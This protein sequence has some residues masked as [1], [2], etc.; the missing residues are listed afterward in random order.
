MADFL[1]PDLGEGLTE[2]EIMTWLVD[3]GDEVTVDQPVVEVETAKASVEVPVPF[4]GVVTVLHAEP[5]DVLAVGT[6]L[7]TI[8]ETRRWETSFGGLRE[9][10]VEVAP[11]GF[12]EKSEEGAGRSESAGSSE[13]TGRGENAGSGN[14]LVGYGTS[15][16]G[17]PTPRRRRPLRR[18][19]APALVPETDA[20]TPGVDAATP[21]AGAVAP[22]PRVLPPGT[23]THALRV[24]SPL[25]RRLA[26]ESGLDLRQVTGS[27]P[28]GLILRA[29]VE[30]AARSQPE[31][32]P[33]P[34][35]PAPTLP[36]TTSSGTVS[37]ES[38]RTAA[39]PPPP[40]LPA[41]A[42][43]P[44]RGFERVPLTGIRRVAAEKLSRS[45]REIPEA[46]LWVDADATG[47]LEARAVLNSAPPGS[48]PGTPVSIV[49]LLARFG[50][51]GL[52]RYPELNATV[53]GGEIHRHR[54]VHLGFAA[55]TDRGLVVP[56]IKDADLLSTRRLA[57]A[58]SAMTGRARESALTPGDLTGGTFTV[59]NYGVFGTDGAAA[60]I[61]HPEAAILGIGRIIERPWAVAGQVVVR[62]V[63]QLTL[64]FD[65]RVCDGAV[66]GG[67]L[68]FVA[69]CVERPVAA[70]GDL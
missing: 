3:V 36:E 13:T 63:T 5:G 19:G 43:P 41:S 1:L 22:T 27:G 10:G 57:G 29:D 25:V 28:G 30:Q 37:S 55:Q 45:R 18:P 46:T 33:G 70:L 21:D 12:D 51:A 64:S 68:R 48:P 59:N 4:A 58:I 8:A 53:E 49:A 7:I 69:D 14:V 50:V 26:R 15:S 60:I 67:F 32:R 31:R 34:T 17:A 47:L 11:P 2:A 9:P 66:A 40:S 65:H 39:S 38:F 23:E 52:R 6:P 16:A 61:H 24:I 20:V 44:D 54:A 35:P 42:W 56:V 62:Q